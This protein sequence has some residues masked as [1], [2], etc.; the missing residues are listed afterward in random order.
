MKAKRW[1]ISFFIL[2]AALFAC[3]AALVIYVDPFFHYH[4]PHA[5]KFFYT[6]DNQRSVNDGIV[7]HF[8]YDAMI[9][10]SSMTVNFD[11]SELD[12]LFGT[13]SIKVPASGASYYEIDGLISTAFEHNPELRYV[14]R[15]IDR[16][17]LI[18]GSNARRDE[19]GE[20]PDYLYDDNIFNDYKYLFNADVLFNRTLKMLS[21]T[22]QPGF[23]P[24]HTGFD[25]YSNTME[26]YAGSFGLE[27]LGSMFNYEL[28]TVG[29]PQHL[30]EELKAVVAENVRQNIVA[31]A[32]AHPEAT[33]YYF[34]PP[35]SLAYWHDKVASGE[36]YAQFEAEQI[37]IELMLQCA[38]IKV[39]DFSART[40]II[41]DVNNYRD[42]LHYGDW[43]NSFMLK[44]MR[45]G[46]CLL[47]EDNYRAHLESQFEY[48]TTYDYSRLLAQE[49]Y[50][51]D[52]YAAALLNEELCG[53]APRSISEQEL[54][55][56]EL[57][58]AELEADPDSG[59]LVLKCS[60]TLGR[61]PAQE[62]GAFLLHQDYAGLKL[63]LPDAGDYSYLCF[64]GRNTGFNGQP[65]VYAY[66]GS[67][68][69]ISSVEMK[70]HELEGGW[71]QFA[72]DLRDA[73]GAVIIFNG[74]YTD[75]TG[76]PASSFE[77][78]DI[79]LY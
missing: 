74:A 60:G 75:Y 77:F 25:D 10:G 48:Y 9:T 69:V 34:L 65:T 13:S 36:I 30:S 73:G 52:Y 4:A 44:W 71:Q 42:L 15:S 20:F 37:A 49:R 59:G 1:L 51:C 45:E 26:D 50:N 28:G 23:Y 22:R 8:D 55:A 21:D 68:N 41:S 63:S 2:L 7:K 38:N 33:F 70:Y 43:I 47:T 6:I 18:Y 24:G 29:Q 58:S 16:N 56:G 35:Y 11:T 57:R 78:K 19:L 53:T 5:D 14:F 12:E 17:L 79:K 40:D 66:D 46:E 72:L 61:D 76:H 3:A 27:S 39:F 54:L 64:K 32:Q 67:G 62:L 31:T